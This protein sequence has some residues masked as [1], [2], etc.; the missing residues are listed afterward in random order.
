[1]A[2]SGANAMNGPLQLENASDTEL[3]PSLTFEGD[4]N[5]GVSRSSDTLN[6]STNGTERFKVENTGIT[7]GTWNADTIATGKGGTGQ[8]TYSNGQLLI[9]NASGGLTK[10]TLTATAPVTVTNADGSI[11]I[12]VTNATTSAD[13]LFS[14]GDKTKLDNIAFGAEVNVDTNLGY[15]T[16]TRVLTSSTGTDVTLPEVAA[17][18][19]SGFMTGGDKTK[20]DNIA[21]GAQ[22]NVATNLGYTTGTRALTSS[23]GTDVILPE[24]TAGG[25]S[26]FMTGG[27]KTKLNNIE[28]SA[29]VTDAT[30]VAAA[31]AVMEGD[32]TTANMSFV[33]DEDNMA[34]N[35]KQSTYSAILTLS[36]LSVV[37]ASK[38]PWAGG[39]MTGDIDMSSQKITSLGT[40]TA[41]GDAATKNYVDTSSGNTNYVAVTG[42]AMTG[43]LAMGSNKINGLGAPT[44]TDAST[45]KYVD[46]IAGLVDLAQAHPHT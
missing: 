1:M 18:G 38:P 5:T 25:D 14:S 17:G 9:G 31:G 34:S 36:Q 45:K 37:T 6:I 24:V 4:P 35:F 21:P 2:L 29:D 23:T 40:P 16:S 46:E 15:T 20:L 28:A 11:T 32:T 7:V 27:D 8:T 42:D 3:L 19:D 44:D 13:G 39:T 26:G 33:V 22:V 10:A 12:D 30:N 43:E 41:T